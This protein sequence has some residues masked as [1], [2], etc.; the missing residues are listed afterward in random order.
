MIRSASE[1]EEISRILIDPKLAELAKKID[2][3]NL[4]EIKIR[5]K[6]NA[7]SDIIEI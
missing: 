3:V 6:G 5:A 1:L 4:I 2:E 7:D